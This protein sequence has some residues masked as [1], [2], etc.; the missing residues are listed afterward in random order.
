MERTVRAFAD[1]YGNCRTCGSSSNVVRLVG[2]YATTDI[3]SACVDRAR[4]V[5]DAALADLWRDRDA[6]PTP[7]EPLR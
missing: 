4:D 2:L 3:C 1:E 7:T 5:A 6:T